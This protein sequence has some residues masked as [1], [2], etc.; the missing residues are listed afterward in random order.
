VVP[1]GLTRHRRALTDLRPL[2]SAEARALVGQ[3]VDWQ[4]RF[5]AEIGRGFVYLSDEMYLLAGVDFPE[6][7]DYDGY[8]LMENGVGMSRDFLNELGYQRAYLP[9]ALP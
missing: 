8:P 2:T 3:V 1:V 7:E 6:E 4:A 9:D 5:R